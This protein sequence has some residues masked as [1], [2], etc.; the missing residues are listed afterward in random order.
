MK[1]KLLIILTLCANMLVA[2]SNK[3]LIILHTNDTHS[4]IE[5]M[6]S[7]SRFDS[8]TG[9]VIRRMNYVNKVRQQ[10]QDVLLLDAGDFLQGTPY[11]NRFGGEVE[12]ETMNL[13]KYDAVTLG[14][15]EFDK[16]IDH[17][18]ALLK[19]AHFP[20]VNCNYDVSKTP[21]KDLV[22]P[23]VVIS[24]GG[25]KIGILGV[26][27]N[28]KGLIMKEN[29]KGMKFLPI[30]ASVNKYANVLREQEK[31]DIVICL[32]HIGYSA[33]YPKLT[34]DIKLAQESKNVDII[35]GGHS[36]TYLKKP[37]IHQN[38]D[39]KDVVI[40]QMGK[41]GSFIGQIVVNF[42]EETDSAL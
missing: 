1:I 40:Y 37:V 6:E 9:G 30:V 14:N 16:G 34:T 42:R 25:L 41:N 21:L 27:V 29:Y 11:F 12:I 23:Y 20:V 7:S 32:S 10:H 39:G 4:R 5:P 24:K 38:V 19:K 26:G 2:Q 22:K 15:H 28:P 13:L 35:I 33:P 36:H 17:L 8:D 31:C 18:A 3:Q